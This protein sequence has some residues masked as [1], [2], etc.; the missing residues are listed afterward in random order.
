MKPGGNAWYNVLFSYSNHPSI[1]AV[2]KNKIEGI[3]K[4]GNWL[5]FVGWLPI[6]LS[7]STLHMRCRLNLER[8]DCILKWTRT[9]IE[10]IINTTTVSKWKWQ[11]T[12]RSN[13][14]QWVVDGWMVCWYFVL[15]F[16]FFYSAFCSNN[17]NCV[18]I[19]AWV[20]VNSSRRKQL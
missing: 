1:N 7:L 15:F 19:G 2:R 5:Q 8:I 14:L 16:F 20:W 18:F 11:K 4:W 3:S 13:K 10:K 9:K 17:N 6:S 12:L